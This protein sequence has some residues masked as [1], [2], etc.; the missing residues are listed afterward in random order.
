[1]RNG[2]GEFVE[3]VQPVGYLT[4]LRRNVPFRR[5][6]YGQLTSQLG[7]WL[8]TI[9]L[10][11]LLLRLTGSGIA[12]AGLLVA[13]SLPSALAGLGAGVVVDRLPRKVVLIV[14]DLGRAGLVLCFLFVHRPDQVWIIYVVTIL[15]FTLTAFYEP[16]REAIVPDIVAR[17]ELV[18]ANGI[19]GLTWSAMLAGG[20]ALGG[21]I[22]GTLGTNLAFLLDG[23]SFLLSAVFTATVLVRETHLHGASRAHPLEEFREGVRYLLAH[24]DVATY[25]LSKTLWSLGG[26]GVLVLLPLFGKE[27]FPLGEDGALSMGLLYAARRGA[28]APDW[29]RCWPS[30]GAAVRFSRYGGRWG[31]DFS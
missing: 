13:Q 24:R 9:A 6:W 28:S 17:T 29:V 7:D 2:S 27:V 11:T 16:A 4:L 20:A 12:V 25:A 15:K 3:H 26:G 22:V 14:T 21:L 5:L 10:Y 18:A 8:D 19:S 30:A 31:W 23:V 1:M